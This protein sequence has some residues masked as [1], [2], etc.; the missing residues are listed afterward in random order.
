MRYATAQDGKDPTYTK[1]PQTWLNGKCWLDEP[2]P[3]RYRVKQL[4]QW[5]PRRPRRLF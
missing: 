2:A 4:S 1:H 5:H 3:S